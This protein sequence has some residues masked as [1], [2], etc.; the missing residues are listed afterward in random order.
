MKVCSINVSEALDVI[1]D[2]LY[3]CILDLHR[4]FKLAVGTGK[5]NWTGYQLTGMLSTVFQVCST[6]ARFAFR[7]SISK[8]V[9]H[10]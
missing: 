5:Y 3:K 1:I 2:L 9:L 7:V 10:V 8:L 4:T 6:N